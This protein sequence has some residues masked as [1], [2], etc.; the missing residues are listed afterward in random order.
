MKQTYLSPKVAVTNV[1]VTNAL[2]DDKISGPGSGSDTGSVPVGGGPGQGIN[3][4]GGVMIRG[5]HTPLDG[6]DW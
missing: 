1:K 6:E 5:Q 2:L 4:P 3:N